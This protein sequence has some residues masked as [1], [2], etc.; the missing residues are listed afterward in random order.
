M[1]D[2][3][4]YMREPVY[5]T[6]KSITVIMV[7]I[8]GVCYVLQSIAYSYSST[9]VSLLRDL[10]LTESV[11]RRGFLWQLLTFQFLHGGFLHVLFNCI[12]LYQIGSVLEHTFSR[13]HWLQIYFGA[14]IAGGLLHAVGNLVLPSNFPGSVVG[15][16][17]G[18]SGLLAA[19]C[20]MYPGEII[21]FMMILPIPAK[22]LFFASI[23]LS[24]FGILV[25]AGVPGVAHGAHLGGLLFGYA[26]VRWMMHWDWRW[27]SFDFFQAPQPAARTRRA[28]TAWPKQGAAEEPELPSEE[29]ISREVDPILDKISA[30]GMQSLTD[31]E[32]RILELARS[33]MAKR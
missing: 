7:V 12:F 28:P 16:S 30:H 24:L 31:R 17:A 3:R 14:G 9:G 10:A 22:V 6:Q 18:L 32:K 13:Q 19:F 20:F 33:R 11:L 23:F 2:D 21:R 27:P 8:L 15:A 1:L 26:Y 4:S 25:P 29:F 5:G